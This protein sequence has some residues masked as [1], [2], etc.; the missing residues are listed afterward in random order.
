MKLDKD[1]SLD[2]FKCKCG[3]QSVPAS[4]PQFLL[5]VHILQM[6]RDY[7]G[8]K[9]TITSGIRCKKHNTA[10]TGRADSKSKHLDGIA[11]DF[12]VQ[13][14]QPSAVCAF[15][16]KCFPDKF[17]IASANSFTHL[18]TRPEKARWTY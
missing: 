11:A 6:V 17:G 10:V 1:F 4:T 14:V 15:L 13:G 12:Q 5:L 3:C 16:L 9:V 18:D 8:K 2:E 7:F